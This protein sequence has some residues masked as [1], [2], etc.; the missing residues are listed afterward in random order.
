MN[1]F[2]RSHNKLCYFIFMKKYIPHSL[3]AFALGVFLAFSS[4]NAGENDHVDILAEKDI[5]ST[6][7]KTQTSVQKKEDI[8]VQEDANKYILTDRPDLSINFRSQHP[9]QAINLSISQWQNIGKDS[10]PTQPPYSDNACFFD[11]T[12]EKPTYTNNFK[13]KDNT[14]TSKGVEYSYSCDNLPNTPQRTND[15]NVVECLGGV[16][17][18]N[19]DGI[20]VKF[21][22][23]MTRDPDADTK[24]ITAGLCPEDDISECLG[25]GV[26]VE[27]EW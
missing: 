23:T 15:G 21:S 9:E 5:S 27:I 19:P 4:K 6:I 7:V 25:V 3:S 17:I 22:G 11:A 12:N 24:D 1:L 26:N 14:A 18:N 16:H 8:H 2:Y 20:T 10:C 13:N